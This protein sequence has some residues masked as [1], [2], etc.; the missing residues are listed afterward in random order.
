MKANLPIQPLSRAIKSLI[1]ICA[2]IALNSCSLVI[3]ELFCDAPEIDCYRYDYSSLDNYKDSLKRHSS[4]WKVEVPNNVIS[5]IVE[6]KVISINS[7]DEAE[8]YILNNP[9][10]I[11]VLGKFIEKKQKPREWLFIAEQAFLRSWTSM[12]R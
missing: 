8:R 5:N 11:F 4:Q 12:E 6:N 3:D 1:V 10:E 7:A 9:L 2:V